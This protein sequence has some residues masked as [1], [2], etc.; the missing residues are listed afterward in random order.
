MRFLSGVRTRAEQTRSSALTFR[1]LML[2]L[3][4]GAALLVG[5]FV[6]AS[7]FGDGPLLT[8]RTA[9]Q[10]TGWLFVSAVLVDLCAIALRTRRL[11]DLPRPSFGQGVAGMTTLFTG[12]F[13]LYLSYFE[14]SEFPAA[15]MSQAAAAVVGD[16]PLA[17]TYK[18]AALPR[19]MPD[20]SL[21]PA[22]MHLPKAA[23]YE[24]FAVAALSSFP[25]SRRRPARELVA[26][27][28][29]LQ[30]S[31]NDCTSER[32][33]W[34]LMCDEQVRVEYCA[35]RQGVDPACPSSIPAS[36]PY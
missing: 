23:A 19:G 21:I 2:H 27:A 20:A 1:A 36:P 33:F 32:G 25:A 9:A 24:P 18:I 16:G 14:W 7:A 4:L 5:G 11:R 26:S 3:A 6:L 30:A 34:R 31:A 29:Q 35:D 17:Y 13:M 28:T 12:A 10:I 22:V 15:P 8:F